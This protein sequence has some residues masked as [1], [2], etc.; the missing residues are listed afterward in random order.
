MAYIIKR[1]A[2]RKL[3]DVQESRYVTLEELE[4]LIRGGHELSVID[5]TTGEE[6][7]SV[8]LAQIL[9]EKERQGRHPL[10]TALLH[11]LIQYGEAWQDFTMRALQASLTG[12]LTSQREADRILRDWA[13]R[14]GWLLPPQGA[15]PP[16]T[17]AEE[18]GEL[19]ALKREVAAL[20]EQLQALAARLEK[21]TTS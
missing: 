16:A 17:A 3:Y 15:A 20:Q 11:Q 6:L 12:M 5:A 21:R 7:T 8:I 13:S 19:A 14:C 2:N 1:Y 4:E 18:A 10:P 9:L